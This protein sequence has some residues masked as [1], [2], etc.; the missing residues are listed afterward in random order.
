MC[1][2]YKIVD[3]VLNDRLEWEIVA[4]DGKK[5]KDGDYFLVMLSKWGERGWEYNGFLPLTDESYDFGTP[6]SIQA[7]LS[8]PRQAEN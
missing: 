3:L 4:I 5:M 6:N 1:L 8:R 2:Q 7:I